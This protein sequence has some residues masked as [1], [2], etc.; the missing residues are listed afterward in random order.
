M[1]ELSAF[2]GQIVADLAAARTNADY[3]A[4][5]ISE[6]YHADPFVKGLPVPHYIIED[7]EVDVPVMIVGIARTSDEFAAQRDEILEMVREKLP[8]YLLR[9]FKYNFVKER[10]EEKRK[11]SEKNR[12]REKLR[13][14]TNGGEERASGDGEEFNIEIPPEQLDEFAAS[15]KKITDD[16]AANVKS[17][18][19]SYNYEIIKILDLSDDFREK[20]RREIKA[21]SA[22]YKKNVRPFG[23][24][25]AVQ[26]AAKYIGNLMFF[27]FKK[28][29]RSSAS[30]QVDINTVK[31]NEYATQDCLMHIK[32]KIKEQ[33]LTL[34]VESD[35]EGKEKRY[36]SLT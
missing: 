27:E 9:S 29:M 11:E 15:A 24:D 17:Y 36:L 18:L 23:S 34:Q 20:L 22:T 31:M 8:V 35:G 3:F 19:D 6:R 4:A 10:E 21:D 13:A 28:I 32:M 12:S 14:E 5:G 7:V 30:V 26:R 16:M 2:V 33:D 25:E 1:V